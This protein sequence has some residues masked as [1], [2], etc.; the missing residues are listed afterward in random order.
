M[1]E[2]AKEEINK[3]YLTDC[4]F[5]GKTVRVCRSLGMIMG[6]LDFGSGTCP[7]CKERVKLELDREKDIMTINKPDKNHFSKVKDTIKKKF[8]EEGVD[9]C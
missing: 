3:S 2:E 4:C 9:L 6:W 7:C 1:S 8:K 5:C